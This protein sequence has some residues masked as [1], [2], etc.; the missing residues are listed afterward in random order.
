MGIFAPN[1]EQIPRLFRKFD[2][3][4]GENLALSCASVVNS[5]N[6]SL[7]AKKG[8]EWQQLQEAQARNLRAQLVSNSSDVLEE[9]IETFDAELA[10]KDEQIQ[11]LNIRLEL[12]KAKNSNSDFSTSELLP[13]GLSNAIGP[14]L[15]SGEFSDRLRLF[16]SKGLSTQNGQID[17]R[18]KL[19][20]HKFLNVTEYTGR[21]TALS[22]QIKTACKDGNQILT[23]LGPML[24]GFGYAKSQ[25]GKH[26]KFT[27]PKELFGLPS[28]TFPSTPSD[29]QRGGRNRASDIIKSMNLSELKDK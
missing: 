18:T 1:G 24:T 8:W 20:A 3:S 6:S 23:Q 22:S 21:A 15:Y 28:E 14:E 29:S 2:D 11:N 27:P 19:F 25:E 13:D 9:Y 7:A 17:E 12:E 16:I 26:P 4:K 10:S 5:F